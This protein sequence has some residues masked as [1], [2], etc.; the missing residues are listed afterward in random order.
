M[1]IVHVAAICRLFG[2]GGS[3]HGY[4][5]TGTYLDEN[6]EEFPWHRCLGKITMH[7]D[8]G[9][10]DQPGVEDALRMTVRK[11]TIYPWCASAEWDVRVL[12][13][14]MKQWWR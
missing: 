13:D 1:A 2:G 14:R 7:L 11:A 9:Y 5:S 12:V 8:V 3:P 10:D 4:M 6:A